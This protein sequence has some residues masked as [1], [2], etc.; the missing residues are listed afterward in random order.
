MIIGTGIDI[1]EIDRIEKAIQ[2]DKFVKRVFTV[3]E[4]EY[5]NSRGIQRAASY[6]ARFAGKEAI[7]KA[8]GTG[9]VGGEL[10]DI[11]ILPNDKGCPKVSLTGFFSEYAALLEVSDIH[12]TLTHARLYA[13]ANV[14]LWGGKK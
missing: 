12:I 8:F 10:L 1:I 7:L 3:K 4:Q 9:L 6:A 11:E 13:A 2:R 14:I 5:C